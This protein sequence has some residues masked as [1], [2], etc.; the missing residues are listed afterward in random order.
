MFYHACRAGGC[1]INEATLL[2]IGVRLGG[3]WPL[4]PPWSVM[5][6][7]QGP[8]IEKHPTDQRI[9]ADFRIIAHQV[10]AGQE[11]DDPAEI[12]A[13]TDSAL[14]STIGATLPGS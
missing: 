10:L 1:S 5:V 13:R 12:E 7:P 6:A 8:H 14:A 11:T 3:V 4:V 2:Y 9:E